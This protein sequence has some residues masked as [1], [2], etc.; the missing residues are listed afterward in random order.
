MTTQYTTISSDEVDV[1][2]TEDAVTESRVIHQ[3]LRDFAINDQQLDADD[4]DQLHRSHS[5]VKSFIQ[6]LKRT[7]HKKMMKQKQAEAKPEA[8]PDNEDV[9]TLSISEVG[10]TRKPS[11]IVSV[12][13]TAM[14]AF[15]HLKTKY[16]AKEYELG[17][18]KSYFL[19]RQGDFTQL[20]RNGNFQMIATSQNNVFTISRCK[21]ESDVTD[22]VFS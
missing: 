4:L 9:F 19:A 14:D 12:S 7:H 10:S 3:V 15:W 17:H 5:T 1:R 18:T 16:E 11:D 8:K 21:L 20:Y 13:V 22:S 2:N 6:L